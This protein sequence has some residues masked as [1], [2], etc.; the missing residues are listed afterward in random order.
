MKDEEENTDLQVLVSASDRLKNTN[1]AGILTDV[2]ASAQQS[3][4]E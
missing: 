4:L 1:F 2:A 3:T